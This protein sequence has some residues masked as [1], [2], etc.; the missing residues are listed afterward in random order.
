LSPFDIQEGISI[1][2]IYILSK[3]Q[4]LVAAKLYHHPPPSFGKKP[5]MFSL[6]IGFF[7]FSFFFTFQ[8][9]NSQKERYNERRYR[10]YFFFLFC[11]F[12]LKCEKNNERE[13]R[14]F[15]QKGKGV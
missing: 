8:D 15:F 13:K 14:F 10:F 1:E 7:S 4:G 5:N 3:S 12:L 2:Y 11:N 9:E 6:F